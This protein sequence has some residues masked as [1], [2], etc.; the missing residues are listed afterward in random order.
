[1]L[2]ESEKPQLMRRGHGLFYI[3]DG[4]GSNAWMSWDSDQGLKTQIEQVASALERIRALNGVSFRWN[5]IARERHM[6]HFEAM[7]DVDP[8]DLSEADRA[9][10]S[11]E[12]AKIEEA[13][14]GLQYG[15][16]AQEVEQVLPHAVRIGS[17]GYRQVRYMD[18]IPVLTEAVK[19]LDS[20]VT[21]QA[22]HIAKQQQ[23]ID[24]LRRVQQQQR[25]EIAGLRA[26]TADLSATVR[27]LAAALP[28]AT[29][30][31]Y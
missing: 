16:V 3:G 17:D 15:L 26:S 19:Q 1:M 23:E 24:D 10:H 30:S 20:S 27:A 5:D 21:A 6:Q 4:P 2:N 25:D 28:Q 8:S 11:A 12:L 9:A 31:P 13:I 18:L 22:D 7:I 29:A 14:D